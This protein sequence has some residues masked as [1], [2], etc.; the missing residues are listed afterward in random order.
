MSLIEDRVPALLDERHPADAQP[1]RSRRYPA[2]GAYP[3]VG[4]ALGH[5]HLHQTWVVKP[6]GAHHGAMP[7]GVV[8][9]VQMVVG[10]VG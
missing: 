9:N 1:P 3:R 6:S 4:A 7:S 10:S 5:Q 8:H 2:I